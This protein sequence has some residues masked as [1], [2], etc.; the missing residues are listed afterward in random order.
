MPVQPFQAVQNGAAFGDDGAAQIGRNHA[1]SATFKQ[2]TPQPCFQP[3]E[4]PGQRRLGDA[5][6]PSSAHQAAVIVNGL[7]QPKLSNLNH[8]PPMELQ[9]AKK[10]L[11]T[12]VAKLAIFVNTKVLR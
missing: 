4:R 10:V 12:L 2:L 6:H 9:I 8:I 7:N 3:R 5:K 11:G 1:T